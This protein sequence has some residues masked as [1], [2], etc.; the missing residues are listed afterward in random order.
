LPWLLGQLCVEADTTCAV[1]A[2]APFGF[3]P[4]YKESLCLHPH[5]WLPPGDQWRHGFLELPTIPCLHHRLLFLCISSWTYSQEHP[6]VFQCY[7]W[8]FVAFDHL[9]QVAL[10]PEVMAFTVQILARGFA[11]L[12]LELLLLLFDPTQLGNGEDAD[13]VEAHPGRGRNA[14]PAARRVNAQVDVFDILEYDIHRYI[15]KR[16][17]R[18]H[19]YSFCALMMRKMRSTSATS[20]RMPNKARLMTRSRG[21]TPRQSSGRTCLTLASICK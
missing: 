15:T 16:H 17:L 20:W 3:H 2:A 1:V 8:R 21:S 9:E 11:F 18:D 14:Y 4:L 12:L 6:T 7:G 5:Q 13:S 19:Q 10:P